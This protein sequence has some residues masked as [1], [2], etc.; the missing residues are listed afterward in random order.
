MNKVIDCLKRITIAIRAPAS[1]DR[2][3][4][5][6]NVDIDFYR[7]TDR[8]HI[9]ELFPAVGP[10]LGDRLLEAVLSRRRFLR[11]TEDHRMKLGHKSSFQNSQDVGEGIDAGGKS[12]FADTVATPI[13]PETPLNDDSPMG[14]SYNDDEVESIYSSSSSVYSSSS[15]T[16]SGM[17]ARA[18]SMPPEGQ[19]GKPFE[20][21][22]CFLMIEAKNK[23]QWE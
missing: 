5:A 18:P 23:K 13:F 17:I 2:Y 22:C 20:C 6:Q 3:K 21:P 16:R 14:L 15:S 9:M 12:E 7:P 4:K 1:V 19:S 11:Y 8:N 10:I